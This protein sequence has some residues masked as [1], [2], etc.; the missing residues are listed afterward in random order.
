MESV[1]AVITLVV[2]AYKFGYCWRLDGGKHVEWA[3][4]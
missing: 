3:V 2:K 1:L 4:L